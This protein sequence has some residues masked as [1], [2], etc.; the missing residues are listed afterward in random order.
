MLYL[1][2]AIKQRYSD[3]GLLT[4]IGQIFDEQQAEG[5]VLPYVSYENQSDTRSFGTQANNAYHKAMVTFTV[6][7]TGKA[8]VAALCE[9]VETAFQNSNKASSTPLAM[10]AVG[11]IVYCRLDS[12]YI[13]KQISDT[14]WSGA[15]T[16]SVLYR[17]SSSPVPA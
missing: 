12:P 9:L 4:S 11:G 6:W 16:F 13:M 1:D 3:A 14:I 8:S 15:Q 2:Q 5:S 7:G 10:S 17:R